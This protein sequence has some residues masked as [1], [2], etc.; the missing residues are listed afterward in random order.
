MGQEPAKPS[1][2]VRVLLDNNIWRY[3]AGGFPF[4]WHSRCPLQQERIVLRGECRADEIGP[5]A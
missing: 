1:N 3:I 4:S 2:R 5:V